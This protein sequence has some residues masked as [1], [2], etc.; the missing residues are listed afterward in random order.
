[1]TYQHKNLAR[2]RWNELDFAQQMANIG[3]EVERTMLWQGKNDKYKE[4]AFD[5]ALELLDL[6]IADKKNRRRLKELL[7]TRE[8]LADYFVFNNEYNT[9]NEIWRKYFFAFNWLARINK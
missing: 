6:T 8:A 1:M 9:T 2:G 3:S 7:R 5:R 4:L